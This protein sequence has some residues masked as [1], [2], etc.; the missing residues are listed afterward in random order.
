[1]AQETLLLVDSDTQHLRVMEVSLR[2]A[3]YTVVTAR[4]GADALNKLDSAQPDLII[5]DTEMPNRS[6][7]DLCQQ[8]KAGPYDSIA[9]VFL[10]KDDAMASKVRGLELGADDFLIRPIYTRELIARVGMILEKRARDVLSSSSGQQ[11]YFGQLSHMGVV[12]LLQAMELGRRSGTV[13]IKSD[14]NEGTLWFREG[15]PIDANTGSLQGADAVYRMLTWESGAFEIDFRAPR[16]PD[17][18]TED[19][20]SLVAEGM[21]QASEWSA[22]AEQLPPLT[23]IF[24]VNYDELSERLA[25]LPDEVNALIRLFDGRCTAR[26]AITKSGLPDLTAL[27]A[28]SRLYFEGIIAIDESTDQDADVI[29]PVPTYETSIPPAMQPSVADALL[30]SVEELSAQPLGLPPVDARTS[31]TMPVPPPPPKEALSPETNI[32]ASQA[33]S[34]ELNDRETIP[35]ALSGSNQPEDASTPDDT[36]ASDMITPEVTATEQ[37]DTP[38]AMVNETQVETPTPDD[39]AVDSRPEPVSTPAQ[40]A[41]ST[42]SLWDV[43]KSAEAS[44]KKA[45]AAAESL[46]MVLMDEE[47]HEHFPDFEAG[48]TLSDD[49]GDD[50]FFADDDAFS[51]AVNDDF[52]IA[53]EDIEDDDEEPSKSGAFVP[54]VLAGIIVV[55]AM[56]WFLLRDSVD[57]LQDVPD[58]Y[59][60]QKW[61]SETAKT[62]R[63]SPDSLVA[64]RKKASQLERQIAQLESELDGLDAE[65]QERLRGTIQEKHKQWKTIVSNLPRPI[66]GDWTIPKG[67]TPFPEATD[68]DEEPDSQGEPE[69]EGEIAEGIDEVDQEADEATETVAGQPQPVPVAAT[70]PTKEKKT[71][72]APQTNEANQKRSSAFAAEALKLYKKADFKGAAGQYEKALA[73]G[74]GSFPSLLGYAKTLI[75]LERPKEAIEAAEKATRIKKNHPDAYL[76]L[77]D[78]NQSLDRIDQSIKAY[79]KYLSIAPKGRYAGEVKMIL[80]NIRK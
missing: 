73:T 54:L 35:R 21:R 44:Q 12:D 79:E 40:D 46:R 76:L 36:S 37:P 10:T 1:M 24:A 19:V 2:K 78:A 17:A 5:S 69:T 41:R 70:P 47:E 29:A 31:G 25:E 30:R 42:E 13:H 45:D 53:P 22:I 4:D 58:N 9:F 61:A 32:P 15:A 62:Q 52:F 23:S 77:G 51:G 27:E 72:E 11:Q 50:S 33:P 6:G 60:N 18:M 71:L 68:M 48:A 16:R 43:T 14:G 55:G 7:Y 65:E 20:N 38:K 66:D 56:S 64:E 28:V 8:L 67:G 26:D 3:G 75:E 34:A 59:L 49:L 39:A 57:P 74:P 63:L 80:R